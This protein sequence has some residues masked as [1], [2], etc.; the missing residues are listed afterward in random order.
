MVAPIRDIG[1]ILFHS[2]AF[3]TST[4]NMASVFDIDKAD[5][6]VIGNIIYNDSNKKD[7]VRGCSSIS[8][9]HSSRSLLVFSDKS[10][11]EYVMK[12]QCKSDSMDQ[13]IPV[14]PSDNP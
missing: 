12:V 9:M 1:N 10:T 5:D 2:S 6:S 14:V 13:D 8:S 3:T 11:E 4:S 7:K